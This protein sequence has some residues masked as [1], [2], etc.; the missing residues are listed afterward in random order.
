MYDDRGHCFKVYHVTDVLSNGLVLTVQCQVA[1]I[2]V[3]NESQQAGAFKCSH[4]AMVIGRELGRMGLD[5]RGSVECVLTDLLKYEVFES[6][7]LSIESTSIVSFLLN[8]LI[9]CR[10]PVLN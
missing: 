7:Q 1:H 6:A 3:N 4:V 9:S 5:T 8:L 10:L 2:Y